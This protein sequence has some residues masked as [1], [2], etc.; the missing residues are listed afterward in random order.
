[1]RTEFASPKFYKDMEEV[2][3]MPEKRISRGLFDRLVGISG[4]RTSMKMH[5]RKE[6]ATVRIY[7]FEDLFFSLPPS[8]ATKLLTASTSSRR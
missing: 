1:M 2:V 4:A 7:S 5:Y 3:M 8:Y 6:V